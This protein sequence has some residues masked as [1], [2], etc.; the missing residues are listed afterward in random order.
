MDFE[1]E[2]RKLPSIRRPQLL[3]I[4]RKSGVDNPATFGQIVC[5]VR[6]LPIR[7]M[8]GTGGTI[9]GGTIRRSEGI[10]LFLPYD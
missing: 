2:K 1:L 6:R 5:S 4:Y 3:F 10:R 9:R 8:V 7:F